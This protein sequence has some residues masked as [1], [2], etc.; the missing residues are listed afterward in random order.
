MRLTSQLNPFTVDEGRNAQVALIKPWHLRHVVRVPTYIVR[1]L[2]CTSLAVHWHPPRR[3]VVIDH[4]QE[5]KRFVR[6][7]GCKNERS[8]GGA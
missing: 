4:E 8:E 1:R 7:I 3:Q 2:S 5:Q 6:P